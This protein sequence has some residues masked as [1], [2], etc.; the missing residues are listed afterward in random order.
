MAQLVRIF[1]NHPLRILGPTF[2][3]SLPSFG[4]ALKREL[5]VGQL[6]AYK[7]PLQVFSSMRISGCPLRGIQPL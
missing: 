6:K 4:R 7:G 5:T 3:W 2:S 1:G